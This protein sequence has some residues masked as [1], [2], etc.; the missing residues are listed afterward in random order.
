[1]SGLGRRCTL[2]AVAVTIGGSALLGSGATAFAKTRTR[3]ERARARAELRY[4][5]SARRALTVYLRHGDPLAQ[6][7]GPIR[8]TTAGSYNWSGY[9]DTSTTDGA[10]TRVAGTWST[11]SVKCSAEDQITSEW[12]GLD[13]WTSSTVEQDGTIDWCF[14][15][16]ANY[17]TWYEMYPAGTIEVGTTLAPGDKIA[18]SVSVS[19]GST[20]TLKLTDT[21][22]TAN[23]FTE[24]ATCAPTTCLDTSAEWIAERPSFSI[25][26]APL[27]DYHSWNQG[28]GTAIESG[29]SG[30]IS[31]FG[32]IEVTMVDATDSYNLSTPSALTGGKQFTTTWDNSY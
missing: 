26:I 8:S 27:A 24:T 22:H 28:S 30:T 17:Y 21:T 10:F 11:P 4:V 13:G 20:Y 2:C 3:A 25:G 19:K 18:A 15:G 29:V 7:V 16:T 31:S 6:V 14:E 23:S 9:A 32:P 12:V 5:R 1:M